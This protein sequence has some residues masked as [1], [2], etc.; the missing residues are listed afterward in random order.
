[1][2][3]AFSHKVL[4]LLDREDLC[5]HPTMFRG[6]S[7]KWPKIRLAHLAEFPCCAVCEADKGTLDVH[8]IKPVYLRPD[9][10][11]DEDNLM[12]LCRLHHFEFAHLRRWKSWNSDI[13]HDAALWRA[14]ILNRP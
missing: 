12:T 7:P 1:M 14:K 6:R 5:F 11:L 9:L 3:R 13:V 4:R 2:I 10:E 8:H